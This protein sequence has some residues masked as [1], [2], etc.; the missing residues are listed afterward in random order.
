MSLHKE[1][2]AKILEDEDMY[3]VFPNIRV[4]A[5]NLVEMKAYQALEKIKMIIEDESLDD[6]ECF[7]KIEEIVCLLEDLGSN[8]G[9]RHDF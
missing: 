6:A 3:I 9:V 5:A 7:M 4:S 2:L 1:I 8:G